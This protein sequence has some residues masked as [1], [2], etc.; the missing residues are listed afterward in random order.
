MNNKLDNEV[1]LKLLKVAEVRVENEKIV[2]DKLQIYSGAL[3]TWVGDY[4][5]DRN[6]DW[7][8]KKILIKDLYLT[9][10]FP[11]WNVI[12]IEKCQ[13]SGEKFQK[14]LVDEPKLKEM[15]LSVKDF[16]NP[17]LIRFEDGKNMVLDGMYA[18]IGAV[19]R[20][21]VEIESWVA[22]YNGDPKPQCETHVIYDLIRPFH[23]GYNRD[24]E[25]LKSALKYLHKSF[26]NVD[27]LLRERFNEKWVLDDQE[28]SQIIKDVI[29]K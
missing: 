14:L 11:E 23:R 4:I 28:L 8:Y 6:I 9:G 13:R 3:L 2:E 26:V 7:Q 27:E 16:D 10:T 20:G 19:L 18:V 25:G 15:F 5:T 24:V 21:E 1:L 12:L 29:E 22:V 17:I